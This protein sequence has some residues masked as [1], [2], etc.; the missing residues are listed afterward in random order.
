MSFLHEWKNGLGVCL[1]LGSIL[2]SLTAGSI[3]LQPSQQPEGTFG[4]THRV[5][6]NIWV[7]YHWVSGISP[8]THALRN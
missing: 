3:L 6:S 4:K 8:L 5:S 2:K 1:S 7:D